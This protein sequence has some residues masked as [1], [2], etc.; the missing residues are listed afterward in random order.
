M[1]SNVVPSTKFHQAGTQ[2]SGKVLAGL[3]STVEVRELHLPHLKALGA[4]NT[5]YFGPTVVFC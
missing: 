5:E 3:G 2:N 1:L 4:V